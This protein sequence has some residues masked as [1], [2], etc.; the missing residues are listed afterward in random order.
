MCFYCFF[1]IASKQGFCYIVTSFLGFLLSENTY[2]SFLKF[3]LISFHFTWIYQR[4][5]F[6]Y[7]TPRKYEMDMNHIEGMIRLTRKFKSLQ[8]H[9]V[10]QFQLSDGC[11]RGYKAHFC[12][13]KLT[14]I[15]Y[16]LSEKA[17]F[18]FFGVLHVPLVYCSRW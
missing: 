10:M 3:D 18:S 6:P 14:G 8:N 12:Q 5:Y 13:F 7:Q 11:R 1:I 9:L 16:T 17:F 2:S 4:I 15:H